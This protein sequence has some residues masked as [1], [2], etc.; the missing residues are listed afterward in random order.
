MHH[1]S[2]K[3]APM[4]RPVTTTSFTFAS[5]AINDVV[6]ATHLPCRSIHVRDLAAEDALT[7]DSLS[8]RRVQSLPQSGFLLTP[9]LGFSPRKHRGFIPRCKRFFRF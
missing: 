9:L 7:R 5:L 4:S 3:G 8:F 2:K 1:S 6:L